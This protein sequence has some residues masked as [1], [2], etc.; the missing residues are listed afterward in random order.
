[1]DGKVADGGEAA[2]PEAVRAELEQV[3]ASPVFRQ[4]ERQCRFLRYIVEQTLAG[5][6]D[7][8]KGYSIGIEV[9][10][11]EADFD[12]VTDSIVRVEAG[13]LR[14]KL[15]EYY[16]TGRDGRGVR[17]QLPKG[18]YAARF[19][20]V[21]EKPEEPPRAAPSAGP[22]I[23]VLP[24]VNLSSDPSQEYFADGLTDAI[25]N[26]LARNKALRVTSFTSV[27]RMKGSAKS[28]PEVARQ[29]KVE[30]VIEGTVLRAGERVRITAQLIH[31][32]TD[33]HIWAETYEQSMADILAVQDEVAGSISRALGTPGVLRVPAPRRDVKVEAYEENLLGRRCRT[34][35]TL[36]GLEEGI[37]HFQHAIDLEP[38]YAE[39]YAGLA[40]CY[41][42]QGTFGLELKA[43]HEIIPLGMQM[44]RRAIEID[45]NVVEGRAFL[46][47][48]LLK[49]LWDWPGAEREFLRALE[50][51]PNDTRALLQYSMLLETTGRFDESIAYAERARAVDPLSKPVNLNL[52]WQHHQAGHGDRALEVLQR[53]VDVEPEFWGGYWG[54]G[55]VH[56][57]RGDHAAAVTSFEEAIARSAREPMPT[58]GLGYTLAVMGE[59]ERALEVL[60][61]LEDAAAR[62]YVS[63]YRIATV[64]AGLG[65]SE[66]MFEKLEEAYTLRA[67]S[68]A[69]IGVAKEYIPYQQDPRFRSLVKRIGIPGIGVGGQGPG[70]RG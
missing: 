36:D 16:E 12:P 48:M 31:A 2:D 14:A 43:P 65:D 68:M 50:I 41:C 56:R 52:G 38:E 27:M 40:G 46:G 5:H 17:I 35:L 64:H 33:S 9:F 3:L 15:R 4:S 25:I 45:G 6:A 39:A 30:H 24:L 19:Y 47:I 69:W 51:C 18:T 13:R 10:D 8:L 53:L 59:H 44:A 70:I 66:R 61:H 29:L 28:L 49:Y 60:A 32:A 21:T 55:H 26:R 54:L 42:V 63:P 23:A 37:R 34:R 11:R 7:R 62:Q 57:E 1:M 67:R 20:A 58:E 22:S